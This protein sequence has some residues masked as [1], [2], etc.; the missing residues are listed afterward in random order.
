VIYGEKMTS[1]SPVRPQQQQ[2]Q[3]QQQYQ[4]A[5]MVNLDYLTNA[6]RQLIIAVLDRDAAIRQKEQTRIK[7][8]L[9]TLTV[10]P[11]QLVW[12]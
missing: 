1:K 2:Q 5:Q 12:R 10:P 7:S 9:F 8:V 4:D 6:E 11:V 3:Q